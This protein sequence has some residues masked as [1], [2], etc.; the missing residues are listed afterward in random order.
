MVSS[1][2]AGERAPSFNLGTFTNTLV[3]SLVSLFVLVL[4]FT[5][6]FLFKYLRNSS[7]GDLI[8]LSNIVDEVVDEVFGEEERVEPTGLSVASKARNHG[9]MS[10]FF[11][12]I[13][14]MDT[15]L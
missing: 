1:C 8:K 3:V 11:L 5:F 9:G 7:L 10:V 15:H 12:A 4:V 13:R 14:G 6:C 2:I